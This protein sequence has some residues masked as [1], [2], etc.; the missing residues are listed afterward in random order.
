[1]K[2]V[3]DENIFFLCLVLG[4]NKYPTSKNSLIA[5]DSYYFIIETVT[6]IRQFQTL[7]YFSELGG[8]IIYRTNPCKE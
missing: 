4:K 6:Y 5:D 1:M 8:R 2:T 7:A 3:R